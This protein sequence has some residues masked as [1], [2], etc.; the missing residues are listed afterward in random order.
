LIALPAMVALLLLATPLVAT[1]FQHGRFTAFDTHMASLS[2]LAFTCGLPGYA[3][4]KVLLPAFYSR[5]DTRTPVRAA[6]IALVANMVLNVVF[7]A[8]LFELWAS[9]VLKQQSWLAGIAQLPGL[10]MALGMAGALSSYINCWLLW[11]WLK[12]AGVY[13]RQPG[14]ARHLTRVVLAC[15]AMAAV[16]LLGNH[17]WPDWTT[18]GTWTR[19]W[20][21]A[22]LVGAG[23][24]TYVLVLLAA[25]LRPRDLRGV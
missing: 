14:W 12:R 24:L 23:A 4:V 6:V 21:L 13:Q 18:V 7:I 5:Q 22:V 2:I 19:L 9:P 17:L 10:H 11:R 8:M 15:T 25:G 1:L 16:L 20:H 3:L